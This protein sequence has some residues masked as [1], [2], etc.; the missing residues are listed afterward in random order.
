MNAK[1]MT[2]RIF[3]SGNSMAVRIPRELA[4]YSTAEEALIEWQ[5]DAWIVRP[6]QQR[7]LAGLADV[8]RA[9]PADFMAE[10]REKHEQAERDW[11]ALS[12]APSDEQGY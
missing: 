6:I 4:A 9:F 5:D 1:P 8:F 3:K 11:S 2:T 10:G 12:Q 7:S